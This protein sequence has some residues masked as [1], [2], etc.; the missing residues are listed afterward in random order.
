MQILKTW[1]WYFKCTHENGIHDQ[2][3]LK[4][5]VFG[6]LIYGT[7]CGRKDKDKFACEISTRETF[8]KGSKK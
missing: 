1:Y 3:A 8:P 6:H 7:W 5:C 4:E 2:T